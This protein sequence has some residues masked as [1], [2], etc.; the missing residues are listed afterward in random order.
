[1]NHTEETLPQEAAVVVLPPLPCTPPPS[2]GL[3]KATLCMTESKP[4]KKLQ[5]EQMHLI[6]V[7]EATTL[8]INEA[9][10]NLDG[11]GLTDV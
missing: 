11:D 3:V 1:M 8:K 9:A 2:L 6:E 4:N 5:T 7:Q 10:L